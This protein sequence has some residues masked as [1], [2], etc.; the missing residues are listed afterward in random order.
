M[1]EAYFGLKEN[2][3]TLSPDPRYL[4][5]SPQHQEALNCLIYGIGEKKG[6]I[7]ITGGIVSDL[8]PLQKESIRMNADGFLTK[9]FSRAGIAQA[10]QSLLDR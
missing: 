9:P 7:V 2:P 3:F 6:F 1:Y 10:F 4:Y 8:T 5:L